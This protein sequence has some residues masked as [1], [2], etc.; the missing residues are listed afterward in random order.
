[1][2]SVP[3]L[4]S[5]DQDSL[6]F[7]VDV[8]LNGQQFTGRP[9]P[10]RYYDIKIQ[11]ISPS[12]GL[13]EGGTSIKVRFHFVYLYSLSEK[14]FMIRPTRVLN[15]LLMVEREMSLPRGTARRNVSL[16]LSLLLPGC[17]EVERSQRRSS[18]LRCRRPLKCT[19]PS[20]TKSGSTPKTSS[21]MTTP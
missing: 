8:A 5:F 7:N 6:Q 14:A 20:T 12:I 3:E 4:E 15:S 10:F 19:C 18:R 1:M 9:L 13:S 21:F 17:L 2:T 11:K 16:A